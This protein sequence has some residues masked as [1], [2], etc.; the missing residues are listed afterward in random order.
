M[1]GA[2]RPVGLRERLYG[3]RPE[4]QG[5][6]V[7]DPLLCGG[8]QSGANSS[9]LVSQLDG[10][11]EGHGEAVEL[12]DDDVVERSEIILVNSSRLP[13]VSLNV[14]ETVRPRALQ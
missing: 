6:L 13:A 14:A 5:L 11:L 8:N 7:V 4:V 1:F 10:L 9:E 12:P 2:V 3:W